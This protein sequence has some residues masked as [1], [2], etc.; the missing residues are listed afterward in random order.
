MCCRHNTFRRVFSTLTR[1]AQV[2]PLANVTAIAK[3]NRCGNRATA[4]T[5]PVEVVTDIPVA[6][7]ALATAVGCLQAEP[8][9][10]EPGGAS[11]S[12]NAVLF[13]ALVSVFVWI[14]AQEVSSVAQAS[15]HPNTSGKKRESKKRRS[16][17]MVDYDHP[18]EQMDYSNQ[19]Q[20]QN[21]P[22]LFVSTP[23][24]Q[25]TTHQPT[26]T[27]YANVPVYFVLKGTL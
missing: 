19:Q 18:S 2:Q 25:P 6:E 27:M 16:Q 4:R 20:Q 3:A 21:Q 15:M 7:S 13:N 12:A 24:N 1:S 5:L 9:E 14:R 26:T 10:H 22:P 23:T 8:V 17:A 11:F